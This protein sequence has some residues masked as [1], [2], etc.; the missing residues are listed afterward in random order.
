[1]SHGILIDENV[2]HRAEVMPLIVSL[3]RLLR[4]PNRF[5]YTMLPSKDDV[6]VDAAHFEHGEEQNTPETPQSPRDRPWS[7]QT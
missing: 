5:I 7:R 6:A 3:Q 2:T 4:L 1:M